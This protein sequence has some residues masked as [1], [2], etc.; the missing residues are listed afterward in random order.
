MVTKLL[1][2]GAHFSEGLRSV[3][4][5]LTLLLVYRMR[6]IVSLGN[7]FF[8]KQFFLDQRMVRNLVLTRSDAAQELAKHACQ[9]RRQFRKLVLEAA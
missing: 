1:V 9:S 4:G 3:Q 5:V 2:L 7:E 8:K 6:L